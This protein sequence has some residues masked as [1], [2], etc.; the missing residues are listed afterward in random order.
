VGA[1]ER[2]SA[3]HR[4][5][6]AG[7]G[8]Y[9]D[10]TGG[11]KTGDPTWEDGRIADRAGAAASAEEDRDADTKVIL[12]MKADYAAEGVQDGRVLVVDQEGPPASSS[13]CISL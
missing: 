9:I 3:A 5:F 1:A 4:R 7:L 10:N 6:G 13:Y 11:R 12:K 2:Y 8:T